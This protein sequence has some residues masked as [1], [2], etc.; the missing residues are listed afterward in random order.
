MKKLAEAYAESASLLSAR[1]H[2]LREQLKTEEDPEK[3]W[4]LKQRIRELT[5]MLTECYAIEEYCRCYYDHGYYIGDGPFGTRKRNEQTTIIK[6]RQKNKYYNG[7]GIDRVSAG[8]G[9]KAYNER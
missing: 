3:I 6:H 1:L 5:P 8:S 4:H 2:E 7:H 9:Y